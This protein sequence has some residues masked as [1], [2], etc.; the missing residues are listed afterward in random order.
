[1]N[2]KAAKSIAR[3]LGDA[4][5]ASGRPLPGIEA[6][7]QPDQREGVP[8]QGWPCHPINLPAFASEREEADWWDTH[9]SEVDDFLRRAH[10]AGA[11]TRGSLLRHSAPSTQTTI[12]LP[13]AD[14]RRARTLAA[15]KGLRYQTYIKMLIHQ[16]IERE[17]KTAS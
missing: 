8:S 6:R 7:P 15:R 2:R 5:S 10:Q 3:Q 11:V 17:E 14:I 13:N 4:L 1:M 16:G 9:K 12:R